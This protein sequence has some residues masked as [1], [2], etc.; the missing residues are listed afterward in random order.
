MSK[1]WTVLLV[2]AVMGVVAVGSAVAADDGE[3]Q[4][5]K[6]PDLKQIFKKLDAD[7]DGKL[8]AEELAK[9]PRIDEARAKKI[10][11]SADTNK[12]GGVC[13]KEFAAAIKKRHAE[14]EK[15]EKEEKHDH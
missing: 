7:E 3:K 12:D 4:E 8:T 10:V 15:S 2:V 11:E 6:R 13:I 1:L 9:S 14:R 5:R